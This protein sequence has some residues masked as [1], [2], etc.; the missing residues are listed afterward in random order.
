[1]T[2]VNILIY[3]SPGFFPPLYVNNGPSC[4]HTPAA[5]GEIPTIWREFVLET[6]KGQLDQASLVWAPVQRD[7]SPG[8]ACPSISSPQMLPITYQSE[9]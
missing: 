3:F 8:P 6:W 4:L 9:A 2:I 5:S 1:M 7:F